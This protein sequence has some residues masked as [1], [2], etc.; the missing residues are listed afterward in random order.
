V[1]WIRFH[2][3][4]VEEQ[5]EDLSQRLQTFIDRNNDAKTSPNLQRPKGDELVPLH[6]FLSSDAVRRSTD[7]THRI[8]QMYK[9]LLRKRPNRKALGSDGVKAILSTIQMP[10]SP[11]IAEEGAN[12]VLNMCYEASN[13][14][15]ILRLG[16]LAPLCAF[17][18]A[19][20]EGLQA[21]A[22]G[23]LQSICYQRSGRKAARDANA[24]SLVVPL[25]SSASCRVRARGVGVLHNLSSD[26]KSV[27]QI[28]EGKGIAPLIALLDA[29]NCSDHNVGD[30]QTRTVSLSVAA[31]AAG[32]LQNM[33]RE[34]HSRRMISESP[35]AV[36]ALASL[37]FVE[38]VQCQVCAAGA[39]VN[40][41]GPGLDSGGPGR[42]AAFRRLLA[43]CV[44]LGGAF[45]EVF[46]QEEGAGN[47]K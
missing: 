14:V 16:G 38:D 28:R 6:A 31:G 39:L 1:R 10:R 23:A 40:V 44:A 22:C 18:R 19:P 37:L 7:V 33:S 47:V 27:R 8:L 21:A 3:R 45:S 11:K 17:L 26:P 12:A 29:F 30:Q 41:L 46:E 43:N 5:Y 34:G 9:I 36:E 20:D 25:L 4:C 24:V 32:T 15:H 13:V 42:R 2:P 35:Q